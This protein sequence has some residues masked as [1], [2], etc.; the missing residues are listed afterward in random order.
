[1]TPEQIDREARERRR[2]EE[3]AASL[4]AVAMLADALELP[5][6][7]TADDV[8]AELEERDITGDEVTDWLV[9]CEYDVH[10]FRAEMRYQL[11][12]GEERARGLLALTAAVVLGLGALGAGIYAFRERR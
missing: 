6:G 7:W 1:M 5:E 8:A 3:E 10:C 4:Q 12:Q 11:R 2:A 9:A